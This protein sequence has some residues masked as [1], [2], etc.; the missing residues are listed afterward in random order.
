MEFSAGDLR[1]IWPSL[2]TFAFGL[3][4]LM[5]EVVTGK[6]NAAVST[7]VTAFGLVLALVFNGM[8]GAE[9][10]SGRLAFS[11]MVAVDSFGVVINYILCLAALGALFMGHD[12]LRRVGVDVPEYNP[13]LL[14]AVSGMSLLAVAN[15]LILLF[16]A[17]ELMSIA[18]YV[19]CAINR[20]ELRAVEG[21]TKYFIL[22]AFAASILLYGIAFVYGAVGTTRL[23]FVGQWLADKGSVFSSPLLA[24][25]LALLL[26]GFGFK[27]AAAPFHMWSPDVY[28]GAPTPVTAFMATGVKAASF[29]A[30]ARVMFV[31][32]LPGKA[33]WTWALWGLAALTILWGN[34]GALIQNDLKRMLAYSSI[35]HA[36]FLLMPFVGSSAAGLADNPRVGGLLFYLLTYTIMTVGAFAVLS[37]LTRD[38]SDDTSID[39]LD[40]LARQHPWLAAGLAVCLLSLAGIPPTMGFVAKFYLFASAVEGGY[41]GLAVVGAIGGAV[42]VYYYLR[43]IVHM[44]MRPARGDVAPAL[45]TP[46]MGAL[47]LAS[48]GVLVLG[49]IPGPVIDWCREA[50]LTL[51]GMHG[52]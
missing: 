15:D 27:V 17:L 16:V 36:G 30:F 35:G 24:V 12:Y 41:I 52:A 42:G 19:M 47:L 21:A 49:V 45:N 14:W 26:V 37:V 48:A 2:T 50:L 31:A 5:G 4:I 8:I 3:L 44:Y 13:L 22:G 43:P 34:V 11:G 6:R 25:G 23:D 39:R 46:A 1:Y 18:M 7:A 29:A 20:G 10:A 51:A 32:F 33:D 28:Q 40:G 9:A 38:G